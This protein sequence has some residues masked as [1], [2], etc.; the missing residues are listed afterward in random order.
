MRKFSGSL[1]T[2]FLIS[3]LTNSLSGCLT[4][5]VSTAVVGANSAADH[6]SISTQTKDAAL[7]LA[8]HNRANEAITQAN[9]QSTATLSVISYNQKVLL[10]GQVPTETERQLA[11]QAARQQPDVQAVYNY[12]NVSPEARTI[13]NINF[14]TW[15]TSKIRTKLLTL[16]TS[17]IYPGHVKVVTFNSVTYVFGL[18]TPEQQQ[19]VNDTIKTT[20]GVQKVV[21]LYE[22]YIPATTS[23]IAATDA[24]TDI[25]ASQPTVQ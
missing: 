5:A 24:T 14:D 21:T 20:V 17:G 15:L 16:T 25:S 9:P 18:L 11:E 22:T 12:I 1:K 4:A 6:R 19:K 7:E 8:I 23:T 2:L 13:A 10:L 3:L